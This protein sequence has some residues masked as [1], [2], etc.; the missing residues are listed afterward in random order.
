MFDISSNGIIRLSRGDSFSL[1]IFVNIGTQLNPVQYVLGEG[2]R[3]YFALME[4]NQPFEY[5][6]IRKE[7]TSDDNDEDGYVIM[8]FTPEMTEFLVPG[9]YYYMVKLVRPGEESGEELVDTII[10]KTKFFIID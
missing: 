8:K 5:A 3:L 6:L 7:F 4:P 2:D 1:D 10:S 9:I